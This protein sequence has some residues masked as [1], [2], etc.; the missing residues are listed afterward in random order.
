MD[1]KIVLRNF[2]APWCYSTHD[3]IEFWWKGQIF[4]KNELMTIEKIVESLHLNN[5][6]Y[7]QDT[8]QTIDSLR[9]LN[10]SFSI[11]IETAQYML[12][13]VDRIRSIPLFYSSVNNILII[14]DDANYLREQLDTTFNEE[15]GEEFLVTGYVTGPDT[16]FEGIFQL[17]AGEFLVVDKLSGNFSV[18]RYFHYLHGDYSTETQEQLLM[19]LN[20]VM[21]SVFNRLIDTTTKRGKTIVVPLSGGLDS[22]LIVAIL[23]RLGVKDVICFSYGKTGNH[24][25][26]ISKKVAE[27]LEYPWYFVEYTSRRWYECYNSDEMR[28][29][30]RY[31]GNLTSLP[32]IQDFLAVKILKEEGIIPEDAVFVPGH[33]GDML[34]GSWI[35]ENMKELPCTIDSCISHL[36][37]R[38]YS[39][40]RWNDNENQKIRS[41]VRQRIQN[42]IGDIRIHD[43]DSFADCIE[44]FNYNE[45]Q[46]KFIVNS[47]RVYEFFGYEWRIPLWDAELIDFFLKIPLS[48]RLKQLLYKKY[49]LE[50]VFQNQLKILSQIPYSNQKILK[51][52]TSLKEWIFQKIPISRNIARIFYLFY[53]RK[54][55]YSSHPMNWYAIIPK[56]DFQRLYTGHE[57]INSF[58]VKE[59][60]RK[61]F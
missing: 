42:S 20:E 11:I 4:Y 30:E 3:F 15:H 54:T 45:R 36:L 35:P 2:H 37:Q 28:K 29:Y 46:A 53:I 49:V 48:L 17:Q 9:R 23:S 40:W 6:S 59:Y 13:V 60:L 32:H 25:A 58:L 8:N 41:L 43:A 47:V 10:G 22:R 55:Q 44:Y 1:V 34:A 24:E 31:A 16:L 26:E 14:S 33:S 5:K 27:A 38:H 7:G 18:N 39:L 50:M 61:Q 21:V 19:S 56:K 12:C 52:S 57:H 51:R